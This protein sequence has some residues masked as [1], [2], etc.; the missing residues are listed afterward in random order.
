MASTCL[1]RP[2]F[3]KRPEGTPRADETFTLNTSDPEVRKGVLRAKVTMDK[4]GKEP[5]V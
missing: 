2:G 1:R 3:L 5:D 4:G